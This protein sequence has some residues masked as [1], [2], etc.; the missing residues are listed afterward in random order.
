[1]HEHDRVGATGAQI[2]SGGQLGL[3]LGR[4]VLAAVG[5][6]EQP[7]GAV[8]LRGPAGIVDEGGD[9]GQ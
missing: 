3:L 4:E 7:G 8:T 2:A 5:T 9:A 1:M 6:D